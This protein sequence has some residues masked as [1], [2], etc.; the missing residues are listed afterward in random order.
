MIISTNRKNKAIEVLCE[1]F[2]K[3]NHIDPALNEKFNVK[4]GLRNDDGT[5]VVA[6]L[7]RICNVHGYIVSDEEKVPIDGE[8]IY[9]GYDVR[10]II[11]GCVKENRFG[12]EETIYL[13][14]F[15]AMPTTKQ[16]EGFTQILADYRQ[17]PEHFVEDMI[18][19]APSP[20]IMNK[21]SRSIL[22]LY[23]YDDSPEDISLEQEMKKSIEIIAKSPSI[24]VSAY[25]VKRR[26]YDNKSMFFHPARNNESIAESILS[27]LRDDR[28]YTDAEAKLLDLCLILHAEHGGGNNSTFACRVLTS[29]GTDAYSAYSAAVGSLKG[30]KHGGANAK[31]MQMLEHLK[32]GISNWDDEAEVEEFLSKIINKKAGDGSGLVY[33]MGHAVYTKS[34]PRAIILKEQALKLAQNTE[35]EAEFRLLQNVEKLAPL[36]FNKLKGSNKVISANVDLYSGLVY[37][38]LGIPEEL[39]TPLFAISRMA[40]WCAHRMEELHNGNRIIRPA[41]KAVA[42]RQIYVP[43]EKRPWKK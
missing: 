38:M 35:Y 21:L 19:K 2:K 43:I 37:K 13:L 11:N 41:Y 6:G 22:A 1:E 18:I 23:S 36:V 3:Y 31:V 26:H 40:G 9:R 8:L 7:T 12:F 34:D 42:E 32:K 28:S 17:L 15:G 24:M 29:S 14:L 16:L 5:G 20:N 4:R 39:S 10:D 25:Q 27:A 30:P 33:G